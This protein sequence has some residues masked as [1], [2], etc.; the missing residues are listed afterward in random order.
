MSSR[1][2]SIRSLSRG[3]VTLLAAWAL[4]GCSDDTSDTPVS[5]AFCAD[6]RAGL[7]VMNIYQG[8]KDRYDSP[9]AFAEVAYGH[10]AIGCPDELATNEG[11]RTF[12]QAWDI[13]PDVVP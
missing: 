11:L 3:G 5:D 2:P 10:A 12:L 13:N 1:S 7:T 9:A 8:V 4:I 6:L